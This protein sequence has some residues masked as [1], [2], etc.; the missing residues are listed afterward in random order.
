MS[1]FF[2]AGAQSIRASVSASVLPVNIQNWFPL[3]LTGLTSLQSKG[4]S[5][6]FLDTTVQKHQIFGAQPSLCL[7]YLSSCLENDDVQLG[8]WRQGLL[9][10]SDSA[11]KDWNS[12]RHTVDAHSCLVLIRLNSTALWRTLKV[13][14]T[15]SLHK[16]SICYFRMPFPFP[17]A[18]DENSQ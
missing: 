11:S 8:P 17:R 9:L 16:T 10:S 12:V 5:R 2:E 7:A 4:L 18:C 15:V 6:I 13:S 14:D 1:Q 3:G